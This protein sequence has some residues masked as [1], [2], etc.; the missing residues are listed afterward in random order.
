MMFPRLR[1]R[2]SQNYYI[3]LLL[4]NLCIDKPSNIVEPSASITVVERQIIMMAEKENSDF[5]TNV[6]IKQESKN[7]LIICPVCHER[8]SASIIQQHP[9]VCTQ[10]VHCDS[11]A[12]V[13]STKTD[14]QSETL[15]AENDLDLDLDNIA[16]MLHKSLE[17]CKVLRETSLQLKIRRQHTFTDFVKRFK[18][19]WVC[20]QIGAKI[21]IYYYGESG[22]DQGDL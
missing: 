13:P 14:Q 7:D 18:S 16:M 21:S 3:I 8:R 5:T 11:A 12:D 22:V 9:E 1:R 15:A 6:V 2:T 20:K 19:E 4:C 10:V 17:N